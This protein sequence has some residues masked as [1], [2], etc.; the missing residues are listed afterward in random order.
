LIKALAGTSDVA[1]ESAEGRGL[2]LIAEGRYQSDM[3][4]VGVHPA[5][6]LEAF[7]SSFEDK[8]V[9]YTGQ[10]FDQ[11]LIAGFSGQREMKFA[12]EL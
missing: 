1:G 4:V 7:D 10:H 5:Q 2:V 8:A 12:I 11:M 3:L 6:V 9:E